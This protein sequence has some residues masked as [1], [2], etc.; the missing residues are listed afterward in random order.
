MAEIRDLT[1][2]VHQLVDF[3]LREGD[4]DNRVYN[5]DTMAMGS[6][7][8]AAFQHKQG[9]EYLSEVYLKET[10]LREDAK[11]TI[12]GRADG[13]IIG[14]KYPII[15]EIKSTVA[16]LDVFYNEQKEWHLAQAKCYALMYCHDKKLDKAV[17]RLTYISQID[18]SRMM[19][20]FTYSVD[21]L[22]SDTIALIDEYLAF[23]RQQFKHIEERNKSAKTL[24]FPYKDFRPGQ[25]EMAKYAYSVA[26]KGGVFFCEAPT[27]IGKTMSTLY[28]SVTAFGST[29]NE[30]VFYLTAKASGRLSAFDAMTK[31]YEAGFHG[32]DSL[33]M[34]KD[35]ICPN[36]G[37]A[38]NPD[39][40]PFA[41]SYYSKLRAVTK[42]ALETN[43]RFSTDFVREIA[44][45]YEMCPFEL[46]LDLSLWADVIILD[47]N[48]FF[49]PIVY[50]QRY[51]DDTVD[52][53]N[54]VMLIDEA[55]NLIDRGRSAY[56]ESI[57]TDL[58]TDVKKSLKKHKVQKIKNALNKLKT[59]LEFEDLNI[60]DSRRLTEI[61][62][63]VV[64]AL[65]AIQKAHIAMNKEPHPSLGDSYAELGRRCHRFSFIDENYAQNTTLYARRFG[66]NYS[67]ELYCEDPSPML[68]DCLMKVKGAVIFSAT[69]QP[70]DYYM[71]A[72]LGDKSFP[73]LILPSPFPEENF[74]LMIAPMVSTRYKDRE[75]TYDEVA[76]YLKEFVSARTGNYFIYFPSYEYLDNIR[77]YLDFGDADVFEQERDM[78]DDEKT[79]FLSR[80]L[81]NPE[82]TTVGLLI[83]GGSFSE[84]IDLVD[85]R[86]I[87]VGVVGIGLAQICFEKELIREFYEKKNGNGFEYSYMNPGVNKVMQA[88]GRLIRSENDRGAALL[89][90]DRYM[91]SE[92]RELFAR[93][94]KGYNL[95][96]S[97]EDVKEN[98]HN[99]YKKN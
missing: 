54:F 15:D 80:F 41:K 70:I 77:P 44:R 8:H 52:S 75:K 69:L 53:S 95:V 21:E 65:D 18:D 84:G 94:W 35:K 90:D 86:L 58:I 30:K 43:Q 68:R 37:A 9:N 51:F 24:K 46:Q 7:I 93:T 11:V 14:Q 83:I 5:S 73:Y 38:C 79:L 1:L 19:K 3:L 89:I 34:A 39:E 16:P 42:E 31:L 45:Q 29:K 20:E 33:I 92:Y 55:H 71:D 72:L 56:S 67:L 47:Y 85:D 97:V 91:K 6:K 81:P 13:I 28:P 10:F 32:R 98:I 96:T 48:Y 25:R 36:P 62:K 59:S 26:K 99:F 64:K 87:G 60:G 2:S 57:N 40:C 4:I 23:Q 74:D 12:E 49:D 27:G 63:P 61:P 17:V 78:N 50:L 66:N 88:V 76:K 82:N 22:L